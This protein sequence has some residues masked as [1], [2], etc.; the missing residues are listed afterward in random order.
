MNSFWEIQGL[1][2]VT[3]FNREDIYSNG[4]PLPPVLF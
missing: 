1:I 4:V 3:P 2:P